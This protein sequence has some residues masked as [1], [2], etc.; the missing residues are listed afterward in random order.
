M[1]NLL[2]RI[3]PFDQVQ[4]MQQATFSYSLL[5]NAFEKE[6]KTM[7]K[8]GIRQTETIKDKKKLVETF[9]Y[10]WFFEKQLPLLKDF[11]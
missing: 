10:L 1:N 8:H 2:E 9:E 7:E 3:L 4:I 5:R 6:T 11:I